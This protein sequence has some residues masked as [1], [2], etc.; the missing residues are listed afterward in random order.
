MH[1]KP[2]VIGC[3]S[4]SSPP[5]EPSGLFPEQTS[6]LMRTEAPRGSQA[7]SVWFGSGST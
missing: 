3:P 7:G 5:H 6:S 2:P 1:P 4:A